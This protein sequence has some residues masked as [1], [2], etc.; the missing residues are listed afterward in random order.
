MPDTSFSF[1]DQNGI[2]VDMVYAREP[3]QS[4]SLSLRFSS[5]NL[6]LPE[7]T[8]KSFSLNFN[9]IGEGNPVNFL[10]SLDQGYLVDKLGNLSHKQFDFYETVQNIRGI[11]AEDGLDFTPGDIGTI[12]ETIDRSASLMDVSH[13]VAS[14]SLIHAL[15]RTGLDAFQD[16][17]F[18]LIG[19]RRTL[20]SRIF[21]RDVWPAVLD[22][23]EDYLQM[24]PEVD[25]AIDAVVEGRDLPVPD[26]DDTY[27]I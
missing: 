4:G 3:G 16:D 11:V 14:E 15:R 12:E 6:P 1:E 10:I 17:P 25:E 5:R 7:G 23:I 19:S 20:E 26:E 8:P 13:A 27:A 18:H 24:H 22:E 9:A 21:E 2:S